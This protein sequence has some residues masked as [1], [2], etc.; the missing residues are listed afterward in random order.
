MS[1]T[2]ASVA[3][4]PASSLV[5]RRAITLLVTLALALA[6]LAAPR[7]A[8]AADPS[9]RRHHVQA[10]ERAFRRAMLHSLNQER[11]AHGLRKLSMS[12]DLIVSAHRHDLAMARADV[13]SH[14]CKGEKF[15][16]DRISKAGYN[17]MSAGENIGWNSKESKSGLLYLER[18]MYHEKAPN[19]GHRLNILDRHFRNI[20]IDVYFDTKHHKMWFTQDFGQPA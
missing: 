4:V 3:S 17:W 16:A 20:G 18:E 14:Q 5:A 11:I 13:M 10:T 2:P 12:H 9:H 15:F 1:A 19:D 7:F 8:A 6:A